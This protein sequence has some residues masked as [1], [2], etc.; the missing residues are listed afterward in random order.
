MP[1]TVAW[2]GEWPHSA[3]LSV[4]KGITMGPRAVGCDPTDA[5][6]R[7]GRTPGSVCSLFLRGPWFS[8]QHSSSLLVSGAPQ[9]QADAQCLVLSL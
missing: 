8:P 2:C 3:G 7:P 5:C 4:V 6:E 9:L 1:W